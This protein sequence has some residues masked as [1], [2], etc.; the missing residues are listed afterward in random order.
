MTLSSI[1]LPVLVL[2]PVLGGL[3][4]WFAGKALRALTSWIVPT[5]ELLLVILLAIPGFA[6]PIRFDFLGV[7]GLGLGFTLDGLRWILCLMGSVLWFGS[8]VFGQEYLAHAEHKSRYYL[9]YLITEGATLG[10]F[11]AADLYTLLVCFE[12]MSVASWTLVAHEETPG[13]M[14]AADSYLAFA[15]IGG[16]V[17]LMGLF[18]LQDMFGTVDIARLQAL[19]PDYENRARL[20]VAGALTAFGFCAK[21]GMWPLHTWLPAAHPVAPA[22]ASALLSG[23]I[24]KAGIF[25]ILVLSAK[26]FLHDAAWGNVMLAF[27]MVTMF[28]G[29]VLGVFS[30]NLKRTLACSSMSQIGF[31]LTGVAMSELLGEESAGAVHGLTLHMLNHSLF[32]LTLFLAAGAVFLNL[33]ELELNRIR[34]FGRG[35]PS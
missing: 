21:C 8:A 18:M 3:I 30:T 14:K 25:G 23:I 4:C 16:L 1:L 31:I 10:V 28:T 6:A 13:A 5:A 33:H 27:A 7:C 35:R 2:L 24:T 29:A 19:A 26:V 32:K 15:V 20:Y 34:G 12:V 22:T 11:L 9:Y 17:T